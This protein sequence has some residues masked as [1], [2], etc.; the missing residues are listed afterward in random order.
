VGLLGKLSSTISFPRVDSSA[1]TAAN[2]AVSRAP[3][4]EKKGYLTIRAPR[5]TLKT[6]L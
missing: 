4:A 6:M 5:R 3:A 1:S 2:P